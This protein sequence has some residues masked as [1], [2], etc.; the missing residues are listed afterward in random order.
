MRN[1]V[2]AYFSSYLG[3]VHFREEKCS[4]GSVELPRSGPYWVVSSY[5]GVWHNPQCLRS[6][7]YRLVWYKSKHKATYVCVSGSR[8]YGVETGHFS[9]SMRWSQCLRLSPFTLLWQVLLRAILSTKLSLVL[10]T[11]FW[12]QKEWFADLFS[13][14]GRAS[15][16]LCCGTCWLASR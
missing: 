9:A 4:G 1:V 5:P 8:S 14:G 2:R 12:P 13:S 16:V 15:W 6:P 11:L 3:E 10:A 7:S